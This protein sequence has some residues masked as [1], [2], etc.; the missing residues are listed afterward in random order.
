MGRIS[1]DFFSL[2]VFLMKF[3]CLQGIAFG[4]GFWLFLTFS[5][6]ENHSGSSFGD[7]L[8]SRDVVCL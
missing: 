8:L 1:A 3:P 7:V 2:L 5:K 4:L 6:N